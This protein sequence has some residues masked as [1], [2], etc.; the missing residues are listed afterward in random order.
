[1][2]GLGR[3][4]SGKAPEDAERRKRPRGRDLEPA[5]SGREGMER[6]E[7]GRRG[8]R[9]APPPYPRRPGREPRWRLYLQ[10]RPPREIG[11]RTA[12]AAPPA[13]LAREP[14]A[15]QPADSQRRPLPL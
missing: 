9:D 2:L 3:E 5:P 10:P 7:E 4:S 12:P 6:R 14:L 15:P 13:P 11:R 1:M 8:G